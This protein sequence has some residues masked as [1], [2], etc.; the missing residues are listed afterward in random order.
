MSFTTICVYRK[1]TAKLDFYDK[2]KCLLN[3]C[4]S[5]KEIIIIGDFNI[6][7]DEKKTRKKVTDH[8]NLTV[9]RIAQS[10][11]LTL[12]NTYR[13]TFCKPT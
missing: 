10:D 2:L 4:D 7:W 6:N 9:N 5:H 11:N 3:H 12:K 13:S 1:P 8:F